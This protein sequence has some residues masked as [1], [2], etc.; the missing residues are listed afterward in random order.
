MEDP[1]LPPRR[2]PPPPP[3]AYAESETQQQRRF[4]ATDLTLQF[5]QLLRTR[6]LNNL[7]RR[8]SSRSKSNGP[9]SRSNSTSSRLPSESPTPRSIHSSLRNLPVVATAPSDQRSTKFRNQLL[10]LSVGPTKYENPGLL[11]EALQVIPLERIYRE[12]ENQCALLEAQARSIGRAKAE[13]G[14]QDCVIQELMK[15]VTVGSMQLSGANF[16]L[17]DGFMIRSLHGSTTRHVPLADLLQSL[18]A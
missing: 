7:S 14:Y 4:D 9:H 2:P 10:T 8:S 15:Y 5:E 1:N 6:R 12:A 18:L 3:K 16:R 13:W 11:D 17:I